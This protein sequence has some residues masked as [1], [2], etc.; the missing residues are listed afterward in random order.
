MVIFTKRKI[1]YS[2]VC[3]DTN[4][5]TYTAYKGHDLALAKIVYNSIL[6]NKTAKDIY[7]NSIHLVISVG[8]FSGHKNIAF[9]NL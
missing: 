1:E 9:K 7:S 4:S 8:L 6:K 2:V 3:R 5:E